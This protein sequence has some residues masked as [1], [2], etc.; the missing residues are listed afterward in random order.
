MRLKF[1]GHCVR[2][3][4]QPCS[5]LVPWRPAHGRARQ[6]RP[7]KS[8]MDVLVEDANSTVEGLPDATKDRQIWSAPCWIDEET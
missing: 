7:R 2:A 1:T 3:E 8:S 4:Q 5:K 6:G